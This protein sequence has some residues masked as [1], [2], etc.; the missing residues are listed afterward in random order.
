MILKEDMPLPKTMRLLN[1]TDFH[2]ASVL[3]M[4]MHT[5]IMKGCTTYILRKYSLEK[6]LRVIQD[7]KINVFV[8]QPWIMAALVKEPIV[9]K[10]DISSVILIVCGGSCIDKS[11]CNAF[12]SRFKVAL[13]NG[14]GMTEI[15]N[16]L[17]SSF[18][19]TMAGKVLTRGR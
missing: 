13:I 7:T 18:E 11:I 15:V 14:Y 12:Y 2:H 6:M 10:Y 17:N 4:V 19:S 9:E 8:T 1:H 5:Y 16:L 3:L